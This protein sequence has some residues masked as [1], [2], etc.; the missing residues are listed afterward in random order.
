MYI[1]KNKSRWYTYKPNT[2]DY[3]RISR[4][5]IENFT[6]CPKCFYLQKRLGVKPGNIPFNLNIAVDTLLKKE[7]DYYRN[8]QEPHPIMK[9]YDL[10]LVPFNHKD[11]KTWRADEE[12]NYYGYGYEHE[13]TKIEVCGQIDEI[14][15]D[16]EGALYMVDYKSTSTDKD[17]KLTMDYHYNQAYKRQLEVYQYMFRKNGFKVSDTAFIIFANADDKNDLFD[18]KLQFELSLVQFEGDT[19]WIEPT[20]FDIKK[21]LDSNDLP[22]SSEDCDNCNYFTKRAKAEIRV[23]KDN[24]K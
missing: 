16:K 18:N 11:F 14:W 22:K 20:L 9:K 13:P 5:M 17:F 4:G 21:T 1:D 2:T 12:G 7:F 15:V 19:S 8:L 23:K 24:S 6:R 10:D 3:T